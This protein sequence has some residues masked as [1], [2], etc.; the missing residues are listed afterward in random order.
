M[1]YKL[2]SISWVI[3][4]LSWV[5]YT[6][7]GWLISPDYI[8]IRGRSPAFIGVVIFFLGGGAVL[9]WMMFPLK[10]V[11]IKDDVLYVSNFLTKV[12]IPLSDVEHVRDETGLTGTSL[13]RIILE[14]RSPSKF[15]KKIVFAPKFFSARDIAHELKGRIASKPT[16]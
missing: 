16:T 11:Y 8:E 13:Q 15:G 1:P 12:E 2:F 10:N 4:G 6:I 14:L 3:Y 5:I 9:Y 7:W